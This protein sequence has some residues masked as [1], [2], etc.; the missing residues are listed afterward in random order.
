MVDE[1]E[2]ISRDISD[3]FPN[4]YS[5]YV[6]T[7]LTPL[8]DQKN[9]PYALFET[10]AYALFHTELEGF[11]TSIMHRI[12]LVMSF[13]KRTMV[14]GNL[15]DEMMEVMVDHSTKF[16]N[17]NVLNTLEAHGGWVCAQRI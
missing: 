7:L 14:V 6:S 13:T 12:S 16:L 15:D 10:L 1:L 9:I 5:E 2:Y 11:V 4:I 8:K 3:K 17:E